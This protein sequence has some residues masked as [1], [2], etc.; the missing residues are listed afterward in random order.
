MLKLGIIGAGA[1]VQG[2]HVKAIQAR[3][4]VAV[5]GVAD[6]SPAF[7]EA[8][9]TRLGCTALY[10]DYRRLLEDPDIGALDIC[11]PHDLHERVVLDAFAAGK[12]VLLEKPIALTLEQADRM[13]AAAVQAG[14]KFY[15]ALNQ[16]FYPAHAKLKAIVDSG[17]YGK[18]YLALCQLVGDELG[19][20]NDP[21][22]WKGQW[23]RAGGGA[24]IDTGTHIVD[25]ILW[26]FGRP[27]TISCQWGRFVVSAANKADDNVAV[28]FGYDS[29]LVQF[30]VCYSCQ[31]DPWRETKQVYF[32]EASV[33]ITM[34]PD[35]PIYTGRDRQPLVPLP[36]GE[37]HNWWDGSVGAGIH[38]W[39]D[40]FTGKAQPAFGPEAARETLEVILLAYESARSGRTIH[41]G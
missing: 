14:R 29:M 8:V 5:A 7:R 2:A 23:E 39:I 33:H 35:T 26:W 36:V 1:V 12:D 22:S 6:P 31:T 15:V 40:C 37:M 41:L 11:L 27:K 21:N 24:L 25:L 34:D 13:I 19:R 18:P 17:E 10:D 28:T 4:D 38:H 3:D 16:R 9:G 32:P 20:L 30:C